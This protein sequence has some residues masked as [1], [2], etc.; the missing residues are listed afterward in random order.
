MPISTLSIVFYSNIKSKC[1][2]IFCKLTL[3]KEILP[4]MADI[5]MIPKIISSFQGPT[6]YHNGSELSANKVC[7]VRQ[8]KMHQASNETKLI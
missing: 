4:N 7:L 3:A 6:F 8:T 1:Q 2:I 5:K